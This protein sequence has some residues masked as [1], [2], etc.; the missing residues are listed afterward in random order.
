MTRK[1][2]VLS[3]N[4]LLPLSLVL[5]LVG[6][7]FWVGVFYWQNEA[8]GKEIET[9]QKQQTVYS[10]DLADLKRDIAYI[11]GVIEGAYGH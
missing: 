8:R 4:T 1:E 2:P 5:V 7:V 6:T 9:L 3:E 11:R 10:S